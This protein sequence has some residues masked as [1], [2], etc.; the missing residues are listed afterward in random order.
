MP[1][2]PEQTTRAQATAFA[3][4]TVFTYPFLILDEADIDV[5]LTP[6][7]QT[8]DPTADLLTL[9]VDYTVTGVGN[10]G[11]GTIVLIVAATLNDIVTMER[12]TVIERTTDFSVGGEFTSAAIN[13]EL[14]RL[15]MISQEIETQLSERGVTYQVT[16]ELETNRLENILPPLTK[17]TSGIIN[18][19]TKSSTGALVNVGIDENDDANTLRTELASQ[20]NGAD[21]ALLVGY[22]DSVGG[23]KTVKVK[24][25]QINTQATDIATNTADI[26]TNAAAITA[27]ER[28]N[29]LAQQNFDQNPWQRGTTFVSVSTGDYSADRMVYTKTGSMVHDI[30]KQSDAPTFGEANIFVENSLKLTITTSQP[31]LGVNDFSAIGTRIEGYDFKPFAQTQFTLGFWVKS[32][33]TGI[34]CVSFR[35]AGKNRS[36]VS[37]Y[38]INLADTWEFKEITVDASP[39]AGTWDYTNGIGLELTF[40]LGAGANLQTTADAWNTGDFI[41]TA[42][43]V[44][45]SA[46]GS[47]NFIVNLIHLNKGA[48]AVEFIDVPLPLKL[49]FYQRYFEKSYNLNVNPAAITDSGT[50]T[51]QENGYAAY[52]TSKRSTPSIIIYNPSSGATGSWTKVIG[53]GAEPLTPLRVGENNFS[54]RS[55]DSTY[56]H[57]TADAEL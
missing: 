12:D 25:D 8:P 10:G 20:T 9:N 19:W 13:L 39:V 22:F 4:Q 18:V 45:N 3:G 7:G 42:N 50:S 35:N 2:V 55:P 5:Y 54:V 37:E 47:N 49:P 6:V 43:Q 33:V 23:G 26:A 52:R 16:D 31:V 44:N 51:A 41:A 48:A 57:W 11:G 32:D 21:G 40:C 38:T 17:N 15:T 29:T 46:S 34:Y 28:L 27:L 56:G 14:D 30:N 24:L 36:F 1:T 53:G